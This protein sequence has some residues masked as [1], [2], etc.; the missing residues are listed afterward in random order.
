MTPI[1]IIASLVIGGI[2]LLF[3]TKLKQ[4]GVLERGE[5]I[6]PLTLDVHTRG[7]F[8]PIEKL[9]SEIQETVG[10]SNSASYRTDALDACA[11]LR[12]ESFQAL[13]RL[14]TIR[15]TLNENSAV[16]LGEGVVAQLRNAEQNLET[17]VQ[18]VLQTLTEFKAQLSVASAGDALRNESSISDSLIQVKALSMSLAEA[19]ETA[20]SV[21]QIKS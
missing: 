11:K 7:R 15:K 18:T 9:I 3:L 2:C 4:N 10:R 17:Q 1:E 12:L 13:K 16:A 5:R 20:G 19:E 6:D 21:L 14:A 8:L